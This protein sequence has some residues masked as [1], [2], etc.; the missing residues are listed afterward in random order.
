MI[1]KKIAGHDFDLRGMC[2]AEVDDGDGGKRPCGR[3]WLDIRHVDAT[4]V[5]ENGYAH[6]GHLTSFEAG[7]IIAERERETQVC[8][9]ATHNRGP[10]VDEPE[11]VKSESED[12][13]L[14]GYSYV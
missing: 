7:Q 5:F 10:V 12:E 6:V 8:H 9:D 3:K 4:Y 1:T 11:E 14:I 13:A 2:I